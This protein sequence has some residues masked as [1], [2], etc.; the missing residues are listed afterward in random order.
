MGNAR[1]NRGKRQVTQTT[2]AKAPGEQKKTG[3]IP[4]IPAEKA[5]WFEGTLLWGALGII[6]SIALALL[7]QW[8]RDFRWLVFV[9]CSFLCL[10]LWIASKS[11][12]S[13]RGKQLLLVL[14]YLL[15]VS[16]SWWLYHFLEPSS[17]SAKQR[18]DFTK[19][20]RTTMAAPESTIIAC[21][22]ADEDAC[23]YAAQFIP[24][25]QRAGWK[26]AGPEVQRGKLARPTHDIMIIVHG[27][28]LV[29]PQNPDEGV[30]TKV[31]VFE[32]PL[33]TAF[34]FVGLH[35]QTGTHDPSLPETSIRVYFGSS[36]SVNTR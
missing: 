15:S 22:E 23:V 36:P 24:L 18:S 5:P 28:P 9:A 11:L 35:A 8:L 33:L 3:S 34:E 2:A 21:E 10:S 32:Q 31:P 30:W 14:L 25:F 26:V 29:H 13:A 20:L 12:S 4:A 19:I 7:V 27:P 6:A 16:G 17:F 1:R